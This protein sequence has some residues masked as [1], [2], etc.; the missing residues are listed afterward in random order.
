MLF[1]DHDLQANHFN[2]PIPH[3]ISFVLHDYNDAF[4]KDLPKGLLLHQ[5]IE[6]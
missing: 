4:L 3:S 6:H 5:G 1:Q 2:Y